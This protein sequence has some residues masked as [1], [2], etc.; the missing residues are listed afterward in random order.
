MFGR[1]YDTKVEK[2]FVKLY[3]KVPYLDSQIFNIQAESLR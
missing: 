2:H 1:H 3:S